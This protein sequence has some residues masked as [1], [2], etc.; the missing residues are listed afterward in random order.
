MHVGPGDARGGGGQ[1]DGAVHLR[2]FG[3]PLGAVLRIKE[4]APGADREDGGI[5]AHDDQRAMLGL[6]D[7]VEPFA[8]HGARGHHRECVVQRLAATVD[9]TGIVVFRASVKVPPRRISIPG[10]TASAGVDGGTSA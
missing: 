6:Q 2:Q 9:H 10:G 5:V 4:E 3:Q 1:D 7:A 8:Q